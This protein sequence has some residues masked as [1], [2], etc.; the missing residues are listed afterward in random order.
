M[1][2]AG[3]RLDRSETLAS[4]RCAASRGQRAVLAARAA[5]ALWRGRRALR[6]AL[7]QAKQAAGD[8]RLSAE[9]AAAVQV[10]LH[11]AIG[12]L[13]GVP[14]C[15]S[16]TTTTTVTTTTTTT[17]TTGPGTGTTLAPTFAAVY[18]GLF[19]QR[20]DV[21]PGSCTTCGP[22]AAPKWCRNSDC[23]ISCT[24]SQCHGGSKPPAGFKMAAGLDGPTADAQICTSTL[25]N[26]DSALCS[27]SVRVKPSDPT[28]TGS[29][30][31]WELGCE[32]FDIH[33][34]GLCPGT[35]SCQALTS[36]HSARPLTPDDVDLL[37]RWIAAGAACN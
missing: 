9:C 29:F 33:G 36:P 27:G 23:K 11:N 5:R 31:L 17:T 4:E 37:T 14:R 16:S 21:A 2:R 6:H 22:S 3:D 12:L 10:E 18:S 35:S 26:V 7:R 25:V 24:D 15:G 1:K 20:V 28:S 19:D 13:K 32:D 30:L 8:G 34:N